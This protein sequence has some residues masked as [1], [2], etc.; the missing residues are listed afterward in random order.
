LKILAVVFVVL[1]ILSAALMLTPPV[2]ARL[3]AVD[4]SA[5]K[6]EVTC[7][8]LP[9]RGNT[10]YDL[11]VVGESWARGSRI[12]PDLQRSLSQKLG[13]RSVQACAIA[14][15]GDNTHK[16]L[17]GLKHEID[18]G[19]VAKLFDGHP[20]DSVLVLTGVNDQIQHVGSRAYAKGTAEIAGMFPT[21]RVQVVSAPLVHPKLELSLPL[22]VKNS[23]QKLFYDGGKD[24]VQAGYSATAAQ[25][26]PQVRFIHYQDFMPTFETGRYSHD[27]I[28]LTAETFRQYGAFLGSRVDTGHEAELASSPSIALEPAVH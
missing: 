18:A 9:G 28:H 4:W 8:T 27:G 3:V 6:P 12:L 11:L 26:D 22:R 21:S 5:P 2:R 23:L 20:A 17:R 13:G 16:V 24:N 7:S 10:P 15:T 14:F 1:F 25:R 19:H